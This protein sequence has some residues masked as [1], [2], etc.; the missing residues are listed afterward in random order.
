[1]QLK[2]IF[3]TSY[4]VRALAFM[5]LANYK[6]ENFGKTITSTESTLV[7]IPTVGFTKLPEKYSCKF[8]G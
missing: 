1:M 3:G 2:Q 7:L 5:L 6:A 4:F 8:D